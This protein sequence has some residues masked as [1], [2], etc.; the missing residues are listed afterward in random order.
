MLESPLGLVGG[1]YVSGYAAKYS[2]IEERFGVYLTG[3]C[4]RSMHV[5][6]GE[7]SKKR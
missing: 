5:P 2:I 7:M 1:K 3:L 6:V 4:F